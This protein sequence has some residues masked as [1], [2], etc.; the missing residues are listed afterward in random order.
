V[1]LL[2]NSS[3]TEFLPIDDQSSG[4][5]VK[6]G[7]GGIF[8]S[9]DVKVIGKFANLPSICSA[10]SHAPSRAVDFVK[11]EVLTAGRDYEIEIPS[12]GAC[13]LRVLYFV[14]CWL[15]NRSD[16]EKWR[17]FRHPVIESTELYSAA[18]KLLDTTGKDHVHSKVFLNNN[19][20]TDISRSVLMDF[21]KFQGRTTFPRHVWMSTSLLHEML[22]SQGTAAIWTCPKRRE[23]PKGLCQLYSFGSKAIK[24]A[25][26]DIRYGFI[27]Y[28][29]G[30]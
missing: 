21:K 11:I 6:I 4:N 28:I 27:F 22:R 8:M 13:G 2:R 15:K 26:D 29:T 18:M 20:H 25:L 12:D 24:V 19:S 1:L 7:A 30:I 9:C 10:W 16:T 23:G 3:Q 5:E 14:L 17:D